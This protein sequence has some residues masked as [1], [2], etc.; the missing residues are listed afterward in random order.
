MPAGVST[1]CVCVCV[2][3]CACVHAFVC[4]RARVHVCVGLTDILDNRADRT[5]AIVEMDSERLA[6]H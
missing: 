1:E 3:M 4:L 6:I 2:C 5:P